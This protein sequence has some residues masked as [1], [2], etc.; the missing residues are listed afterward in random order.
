MGVDA[1]RRWYVCGLLGGVGV[2][3][4]VR[5]GGLQCENARMCV[6]GV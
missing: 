3:V 2:G 1:L 4:G 5:G 6:V